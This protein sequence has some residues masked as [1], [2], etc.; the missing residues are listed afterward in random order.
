MCYAQ[1]LFPAEAQAWG[2]QRSKWSEQK[3]FEQFE[4]KGI[5]VVFSSPINNITLSNLFLY[6]IL[7]IYIWTCIWLQGNEV[8]GCESRFSPSSVLCAWWRLTLLSKVDPCLA[9][10]T[11][12][13]WMESSLWR[14]SVCSPSPTP[15][16]G[17]P[18]VN[19]GTAQPLTG[20]GHGVAT[21]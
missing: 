5:S 13:I 19:M 21:W 4:H 6:L 15:S 18:M 7:S 14:P 16:P 2:M 1:A 20:A 17:M 3:L 9:A 10:G 11:D 12:A 8:R